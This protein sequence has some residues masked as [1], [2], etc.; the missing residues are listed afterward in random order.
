MM[1]RHHWDFFDLVFR[2]KHLGLQGLF[3]SDPRWGGDPGSKSSHPCRA[4]C[5]RVLLG[6]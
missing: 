2:Q 4:G 3:L 5:S 6:R 1:P